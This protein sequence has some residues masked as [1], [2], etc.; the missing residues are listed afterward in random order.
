MTLE[1]QLTRALR[2]SVDTV[3]APVADLVAGGL[4]L[5]R[6]RRR[7]RTALTGAGAAL[8]VTAS[9]AGALSLDRA[10]AAVPPAGRN[11]TWMRPGPRASNGNSRGTPPTSSTTLVPLVSRTRPSTAEPSTAVRTSRPRARRQWR[12]SVSGRSTPGEDT[13][14]V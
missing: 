9:L 7:R 8:A 6:A 11:S 5:G 3:Q 4:A 10:P 1:D 13:S 12:G 2:T 14:R